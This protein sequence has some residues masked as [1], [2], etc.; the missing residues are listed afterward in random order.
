MAVLKKKRSFP[1]RG[2]L[3]SAFHLS[4]SPRQTRRQHME[5]YPFSSHPYVGITQIR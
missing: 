5:K 4:K 2:K 3:R 1:A